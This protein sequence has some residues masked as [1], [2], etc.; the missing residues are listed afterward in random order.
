M[1]RNNDVFGI[2]VVNDD[3]AMLA[4][5]K[6]Y[7]D[8]QPE[9]ISVF[10]KATGLT[11]DG[12]ASVDEFFLALGLGTNTLEDVQNSITP[13]KTKKI[14]NVT[15][16]NSSTG[17]NMIV[18]IKD[19]KA[20]CQTEYGLRIEIQNEAIFKFQGNN[21]FSKAYIVN[22]NCCED[23]CASPDGECNEIT[24]KLYN[25][26]LNNEW[27]DV[28]PI[29]AQAL[30]A[31]THRTSVNYAQNARMTKADVEAL[32][33]FNKTADEKDKVCTW[34]ELES[35][36][37]A[38]K[39]FCNYSTN[40]ISLKGTTLKVSLIAGMEC[41]GTVTVVQDMTYD[42]GLGTEVKY[43]EL[44]AGG[45]TGNPGPYRV[46]ASFGLAKD[47][48]TRAVATDKYAMVTIEYQNHSE[49]GWLEYEDDL[50]QYIAFKD[51]NL[52]EDFYDL[53]VALRNLA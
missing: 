46:N 21:Q 38:I 25:E 20:R 19:Y 37:I 45:W 17:Q 11:V 35:N 30:T 26:L 18:R 24:L 40:Y 15:L 44:Q 6:T 1:G 48:N 5:D 34:L 10:N 50:C 14:Q 29:A 22:T 41:N 13:I 53:I 28:Y 4:K 9:Q 23:S 33:E 36:P 2:L 42:R 16:T 47:V 3:T 52:A 7:A 32:I 12:T 49:S 27:F 51:E 31:V 8:L 39:N 43:L